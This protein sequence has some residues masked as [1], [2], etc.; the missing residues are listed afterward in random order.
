MDDDDYDN[1]DTIVVLVI[2]IPFSRLES[3]T[4]TLQHESTK[5]IQPS[6][7]TTGS[8]RDVQGAIRDEMPW[9]GQLNR[10][11]GLSRYQ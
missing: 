6:I 11:L 1:Y 5:T 10:F 7:R 4:L 2:V 3:Q 8:T 9:D